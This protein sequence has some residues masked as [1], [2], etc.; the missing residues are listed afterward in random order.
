MS[1]TSFPG[2]REHD[3][4]MAHIAKDH[5][6]S[7]ETYSDQAERVTQCTEAATWYFNSATKPQREAY[8]RA[9]EDLR[10]LYAPKYTRMREAAEAAWY[11]STERARELLER[12]FEDFM[13]DGECSEATSDLWDE[14]AVDASKKDA[15]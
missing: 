15:A 10:G 6:R 5:W 14:L 11:A 13:R 2:L 12:T 9:M 8:R 4:R 7:D 1:L 3:E